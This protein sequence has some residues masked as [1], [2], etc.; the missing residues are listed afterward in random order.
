MDDPT[1]R[2][3]L[4]FT[5]GLAVLGHAGLLLALLGLLRWWIIVPL[6]IGANLLGRKTWRELARASN[7]EPAGSTA[8]NSFFWL[9]PAAMLLPLLV[10]PLYPATVFDATMYHLPYA[11]AFAQTGSA[12][13]LRD[14]R[15]P[16]FPQL[17]EVLF[18]IIFPGGRDLAAQCLSVTAT[19]LTALLLVGWGR[20]EDSPAAGWLA[21]AAFLGNPIVAFFGA[22]P[23]VEPGLI[24][25][26]TAAFLSFHRWQATR[27]E[28]FLL[29]AGFFAGTTASVKYLG[30]FLVASLGAAC[31]F[32]ARGRRARLCL[33]YSAAALV[34]LAPWYLRLLLET[35]NPVFPYF[36]RLFGSS[37]WDLSRFQPNVF[38]GDAAALPSLAAAIGSLLL[39]FVTLPFDLLF[40]RRH[41]DWHP[42]FSPFSLIAAP[43]LVLGAVL[44]ARWRVLL[45]V[46]AV[47]V[48]F[49]L[50]L[51][52]DPR[53][54]LPVWPLLTFAA[55]ALALDMLRIA[56]VRWPRPAV[57][58]AAALLLAPA[59][60]LSARE[61]K[62]RGPPPVS[63]EARDRYLSKQLPIYPA[64]SFL[65]HTAGPRY[66][67]YAFSAE[68]MVYFA[69]GRFQGDFF[70]P[71]NFEKVL[72]AAATPRELSQT[73]RGLG[74]D[75]L[76]LPAMRAVPL[77]VSDPGFPQF[78]RPIYGDP[79]ARVYLLAP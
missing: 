34:A 70:G 79:A 38:R 33:V 77:P 2:A 4:A 71:A 10:L 74:A 20:A 7:A 59:A 22:T 39:R 24:L 8:P 42:P 50:T 14:L 17:V 49:A 63:S 6:L 55:T 28:G 13:F 73:L 64:I 27:A 37:P 41:F 30:L 35:G 60:F 61:I 40:M 18:A 78:F 25:F 47:Y 58:I 36:A 9:L 54:L 53:Y 56:G 5:A 48:L 32:A 62:R 65:N 15:F 19:L 51:P 1:A 75:H 72:R 45:A 3:A 69:E 23:Y 31:L 67:L 11:K 68:N 52:R 21:A 44:I 29:L 66:S 12:P 76:L 43:A 57:A 46:A 16:V 26:A